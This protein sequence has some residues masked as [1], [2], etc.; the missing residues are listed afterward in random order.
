MNK[1]RREFIKDAAIAGTVVAVGA[2]TRVKKTEA[3]EEEIK[4]K[5]TKCPF[6]DQPLMCNGPDKFGK[7]RCDE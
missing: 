2:N 6:F 1:T 5:Q 3:I 4:V 7:Y